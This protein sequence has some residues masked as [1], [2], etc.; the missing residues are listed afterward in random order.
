[1]RSKPLT[2]SGNRL[3]LNVA[4]SA[5][6]G[7]RVELQDDAG[8]PYPGFSLDE[9]H[10]IIGDEIAR[11]VS[12]SGGPDV[13]ELAGRPVRVRFVFNDADIYAICFHEK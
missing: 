3:E 13:S 10:E 12:W 2:F 11:T 5:A 4:T 9:C 1:M 7:V 8:R 6:G